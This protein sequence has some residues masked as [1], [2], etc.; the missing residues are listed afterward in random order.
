MK[1]IGLFI[2]F[3]LWFS[4]SNAQNFVWKAQNSGIKSGNL[5]DVVFYN[6]SFGFAIG[7]NDTINYILKTT[8]AGITWTNMS[9]A[10]TAEMVRACDFVD[11][12]TWF[13]VGKTG[14]LYKTTNTGDTWTKINLGTNVNLLDISSPQKDA[15]YICT[16]AGRYITY[17][18][19]G[20]KTVTVKT[21]DNFIS[22][23]FSSDTTGFLTASNGRIWRTQN[24]GNNWDTVKKTLEPLLGSHFVTENVGY[25]VGPNR[26]VKR[27]INAG[28]LWSDTNTF[29]KAFWGI[30]YYTAFFLNHNFGFIG[31]TQGTLLRT[32]TG[33]SSWIKE[34]TGIT[35]TINK[36]C[37]PSP[38]VGY[39]V[40]NGGYILKRFDASSVNLP[41][42]E[43]LSIYPNPTQN[44]IFFNINNSSISSFNVRI[45]DLNGKELLHLHNTFAPE[46]GLDVSFL[47]HGIYLLIIDSENFRAHSKLIIE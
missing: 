4:F 19:S 17:D 39:A 46:N 40:A 12:K 31:G 2:S 20:W 35:T 43:Q 30:D 6:D 37:I 7:N 38:T 26:F 13:V 44:R 16:E 34:N 18:G 45:F 27:T 25:I 21:T 23:D 28:T 42:T 9:N 5:Y 33:G 15:V 11:E 14:A 41:S 32:P 22:V 10:T 29:P 8:D 3:I 1:K 24:G 47:E 36:I